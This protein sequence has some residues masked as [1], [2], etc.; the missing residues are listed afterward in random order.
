MVACE[1]AFCLGDM[2]GRSFS[3][4]SGA[5]SFGRSLARSFVQLARLFSR[6]AC[7]RALSRSSPLRSLAW[8]LCAISLA[9][10]KRKWEACTHANHLHVLKSTQ[11][12]TVIETLF[13]LV[14][15]ISCGPTP[16]PCICH[17]N[18]KATPFLYLP[19]AN[20]RSLVC[21]IPKA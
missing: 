7:L 4:L 19:L 16:D 1:Q 12:A 2:L 5:R 8:L 17:F 18:R 10:R 14:S 3:W 15:S 21:H 9:A 20:G 13:E 6:A 11:Q